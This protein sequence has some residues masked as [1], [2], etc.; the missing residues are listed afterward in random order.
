MLQ[1]ELAKKQKALQLADQATQLFP[2]WKDE[3][4]KVLV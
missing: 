1:K 3:R 4:P 2:T